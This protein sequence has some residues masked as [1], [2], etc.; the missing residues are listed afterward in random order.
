[1]RTASFQLCNFA[2]SA[3]SCTQ[4]YQLLPGCIKFLPVGLLGRRDTEDR[5]ALPTILIGLPSGSEKRH[6]Q[7]P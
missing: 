5:T 3:N 6:I 4:F 2:V 7:L 1:M